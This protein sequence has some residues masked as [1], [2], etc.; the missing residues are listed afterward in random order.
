MDEWWLSEAQQ[1]QQEGYKMINTKREGLSQR[2]GYP[3]FT[4]LWAHTWK[5]KSSLKYAV[6]L[7]QTV[8]KETTEKIN[9][10][11]LN[12]QSHT[13]THTNGLSFMPINNCCR[14]CS[15]DCFVMSLQWPMRGDAGL[16]HVCWRWVT[17]SWDCGKVTPGGQCTLS[18]AVSICLVCRC[19]SCSMSE[20]C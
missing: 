14:I 13:Y 3:L 20:D 11:I 18:P 9:A 19:H 10:H 16:S 12:T 2:Q 17:D 7:H 15:Q 6:L 1:A 4:L 5:R 8:I